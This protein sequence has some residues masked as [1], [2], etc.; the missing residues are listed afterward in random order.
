MK[1]YRGVLLLLQ[2]VSTAWTRSEV[3]VPLFSLVDVLKQMRLWGEREGPPCN[4]VYEEFSSHD[5]PFRHSPTIIDIVLA[6]YYS[7]FG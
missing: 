1:S 4:K 7:Y 2:I 3:F 5:E 6:Y